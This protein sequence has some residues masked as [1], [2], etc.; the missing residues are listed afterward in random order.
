MEDRQDR[1]DMINYQQYQ[2][3]KWQGQIEKVVGP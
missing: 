2:I 1:L 3:D